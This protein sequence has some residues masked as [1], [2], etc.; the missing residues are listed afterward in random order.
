MSVFICGCDGCKDKLPAWAT[1]PANARISAA[2]PPPTSLQQP[3]RATALQQPQNQAQRE[4]RDPP[5]PV[6]FLNV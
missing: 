3:A 6:C 4:M 1:K 2:A 5:P